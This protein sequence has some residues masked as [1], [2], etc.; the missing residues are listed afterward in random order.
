MMEV[1]F[2]KIG[3]NG[4]GKGDIFAE[5]ELNVIDDSPVNPDIEFREVDTSS[6]KKYTLDEALNE[7]ESKEITFLPF[8]NIESQYLNVVYRNGNSYEVMVPTF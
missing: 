2:E 6:I 3:S 1:P 4:N 8:F 7:F 5:Y